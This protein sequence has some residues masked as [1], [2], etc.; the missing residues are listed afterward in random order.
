V[1]ERRLTFGSAADE[2]AAH[3]PDYPDSA[4]EWAL[5]GAPGP[6]VLDLA[7]GTGKLTARLLHTQVTA[8]EP[9]PEMLARLRADLP[10]VP[11]LQG[12]AEEIP[13]PDASVD[14]VL[15][16]QAIH[17][18][19]PE[20]A[21]PEIA[22]VLRPGGVFAGL[23]NC[24]DG[25]VDWVM[26]LHEALAHGKGVPQGGDAAELEPRGPFGAVERAT[27]PFVRETTT[28][29]LVATLRTHSW[30]LISTDAEREAAFDRM[31]AYLATRAE[32]ASGTFA[33]PLFTL[34]LRTFR[35]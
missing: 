33:L 14:A 28:E 32:T 34:V 16:G 20:R 7:A 2:Y 13:L 25:A 11:A 17:W 1:T 24:D 15:V 27:F 23:W 21:W 22:R 12:S 10:Q 26:G 3:R 30:S 31:R 8:I 5:A 6:R 19:D 9:D 4:A 35:S 29:G 18:F